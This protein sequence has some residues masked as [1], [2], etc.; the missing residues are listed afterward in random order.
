MKL[1]LS[2]SNIGLVNWGA[3]TSAASG[4]MPRTIRRFHWSILSKFVENQVDALEDVDG[5]IISNIFINNCPGTSLVEGAGVTGGGDVL[6]LVAANNI[7]RMGPGPSV[8]RDLNI[9]YEVYTTLLSS[10]LAKK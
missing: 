10:Y 7:P 3:V 9:K 1:F 4:S 8:Q 6:V 5:D 2:E